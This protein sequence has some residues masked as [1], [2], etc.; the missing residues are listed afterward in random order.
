MENNNKKDLRLKISKSLS[1]KDSYI[2]A[3]KTRIKQVLTNLM[4]NA[5]KFTSEGFINFGYEVNESENKLIFFV[6]DTGIGIPE[7]KRREI[8]ERFRQADESTSRKFEGTGLGL[9]ISR[10]LVRMMGGRIWVESIVNEGSA[11]Y[12]TIPVEKPVTKNENKKGY[13]NEIINYNWENHKILVVEDDPVSREYLKEILKETGAEVLFAQSGNEGYQT[14]LKN[15]DLSMILMDIQ[16]P[17]KN[18]R[19]VTKEIK[20]KNNSIPIIAQTAYA[21]QEDRKKCINAGC[22]D[23]VTKPIDRSALLSIMSKYINPPYT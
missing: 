15:N 13:L 23:Y 17:D 18:G 11:F 1:R 19:E 6:S 22:I 10:S 14:F 2:Y 4:S 5:F 12:F 16:L 9:A 20:M 21:M 8:F 7:D 3:D